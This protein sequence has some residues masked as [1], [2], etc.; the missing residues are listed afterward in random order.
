[1]D[2][3]TIKWIAGISIPVVVT[4]AVFA[5]NR[6]AKR[7][8]ERK[9]EQGE[10][11]RKHFVELCEEVKA[12]ISDV[13]IGGMYGLIVTYAGGVPQYHPDF[14]AM[15]LPKLADSFCAHFPKEAEK[16]GEQ[17][18]KILRNNQS[19]KDLCQK[20]K[21]D[22]ESESISMAN[23][24]LPPT[25]SPVV[26]DTIFWPLFSWWDYR[27]QGKL[28]PHPNFEQIETTTDFGPN[29]LVAS[30][31]NSGAIAYAIK[32]AEKE[33]CKETI[34]RIAYRADYEEEAASIIQAANEILRSFRAFRT[35]I[36]DVLE[37]INKLWPGTK[38]CIFKKEKKKCA[39]CK[40]I[41]D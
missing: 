26:Y 35:H 6:I 28:K 36:I 12:A 41:F 29:H 21:A 27:N 13:K 34:S 23:A 38:A 25:T 32:P 14:V 8:D 31:W 40:Q 1:M 16:Y 3:D 37:D 39:K 24:N 4:I 18:S 22:F 7:N 30:G 9:K 5:G 15:E 10:K 20:I 17:I 11:L 33:R 2:A 19:Y